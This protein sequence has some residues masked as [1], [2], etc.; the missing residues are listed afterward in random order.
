MQ[1]SLE[2]LGTYYDS[3]KKLQA[4]T[5]QSL[6]LTSESVC[7]MSISQQYVKP[8]VSEQEVAATISSFN[9]NFKA[10]M[11]DKTGVGGGRREKAGG[12]GMAKQLA[13]LKRAAKAKREAMEKKKE[14][15]DAPQVMP[16]DEKRK[17]QEL[18][19]KYV[20]FLHVF[21]AS[22]HGCFAVLHQT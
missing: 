7:L 8:Q 2:L 21:L 15:D 9:S 13:K 16:E 6:G 18:I 20:K 11:N 4:T 19:S 22:L 14:K 3:N 10:A 17:Q 1:P 12:G 5:L